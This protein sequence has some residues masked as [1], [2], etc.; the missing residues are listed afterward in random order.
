[1]KGL[2]GHSKMPARSPGTQNVRTYYVYVMTNRRGTLYTGMTND[3]PR[4]L[5]EHRDGF[6]TFTSRY[7]LTKLIYFEMTEEV[8]TAI[9]R[10]KQIK[11]WT[12]AKKLALMRSRNA[13]LKDLSPELFGWRAAP[14]HRPL[15]P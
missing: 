13:A 8:Q 3:L 4:R 2:S 1:M 14:W 5:E 6:S 9:A 12:R 11:G 15:S 7:R 10:E